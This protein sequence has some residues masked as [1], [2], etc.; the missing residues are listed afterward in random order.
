MIRNGW[1]T[2]EGA[3]FVLSPNAWPLLPNPEHCCS[4]T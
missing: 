1:L 2:Y 4:S 3:Q